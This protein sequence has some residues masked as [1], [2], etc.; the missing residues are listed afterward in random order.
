MQNPLLRVKSFF[1]EARHI[2]TVSYKPDMDTF[3]RTLKIVLLGILVLGILSFIIS[4]I[5][6]LLT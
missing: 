1:Q 2:M 5:V 4:Q 3:K 6:N